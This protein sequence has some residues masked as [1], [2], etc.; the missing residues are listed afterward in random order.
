MNVLSYFQSISKISK[1][2]KIPDI[3]QNHR[4][5]AT[6]LTYVIYLCLFRQLYNLCTYAHINVIF[7]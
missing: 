1:Y 6:H 7:T 4:K 3:I 5:K 2:Y